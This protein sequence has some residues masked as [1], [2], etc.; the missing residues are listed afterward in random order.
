MACASGSWHL[1]SR[2]IVRLLGARRQLRTAQ[3][4]SRESSCRTHGGCRHC[5]GGSWSPRGKFRQTGHAPLSSSKFQLAESRPY[6]ADASRPTGPAATEASA[7]SLTL[8]LDSTRAAFIHH[9]QH[10]IRVLSA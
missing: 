4:F 8:L 9:E 10:K 1:G 2:S 5:P 7:P 3:Y 6:A